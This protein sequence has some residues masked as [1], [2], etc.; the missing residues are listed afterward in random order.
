M[1]GSA[2]ARRLEHEVAWITVALGAGYAGALAVLERRLPIKPRW[3]ALEVVGGVLLV[4]LPVLSTARKASETALS[5]R[6]YER[7]VCAGFVGAGIPILLWQ[8][9]EYGVLRRK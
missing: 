5:W 8:A 9:I 3:V 4:G 7:F 2:E 6:D 1:S